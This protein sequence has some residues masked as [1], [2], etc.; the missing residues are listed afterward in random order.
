MTSPDEMLRKPHLNPK[1]VQ[2]VL[3]ADDFE[4]SFVVL[5]FGRE[6]DH[7]SRCMARAYRDLQRTLRGIFKLDQKRELREAADRCLRDQLIRA[8]SISS[9]VEF[10]DWHRDT[11]RRLCLLYTDKSF[12][13][14]SAGHAQKWI[15]MTFKYIYLMK[16]RVEGFDHLYGFC[17]VPLDNILL[18]ELKKH[19]LP[20]PNVAWSKLSYREYMEAQNWLRQ[21]FTQTSLLDVEFRLWLGRHMPSCSCSSPAPVG[22]TGPNL[23]LS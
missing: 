21:H 6:G 22:A 11:C 7:L 8:K 14:F 3:T 9:A 4:E 19:E 16:G 17:H 20:V 5:Y 1:E 13:A 12:S 23:E 18:G 2:S 15:N 10:D